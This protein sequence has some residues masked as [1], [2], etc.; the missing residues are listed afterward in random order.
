MAFN[1]TRCQPVSALL[2]VS[3]GGYYTRNREHRCKWQQRQS[4]PLKYDHPGIWT[5]KLKVKIKIR[6]LWKCLVWCYKTIYVTTLKW[7]ATKSTD[8]VRNNICMNRQRLLCLRTMITSH[9]G[10]EASVLMTHCKRHSDV[11]PPTHTHAYSPMYTSW[12]WSVCELMIDHVRLPG[13]NGL[14]GVRK[15]GGGEVKGRWGGYMEEDPLLLPWWG[16]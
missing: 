8:W 11:P 4:A 7:A 6:Q 16:C 9:Y 3:R 10:A 15:G 2:H 12:R 1:V 14:E 5:G 13:W